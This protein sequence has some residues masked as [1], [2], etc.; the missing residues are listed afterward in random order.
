MDNGGESAKHETITIA[1]NIDI[2]F[3]K[4]YASYKKDTIENGNRQLRRD[5]PRE[6]LIDKYA[7]IDTILN[8]VNNRPLKILV[9]KTPA[10]YYWNV[11]G[12]H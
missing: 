8:Q 10:E 12:K 9:H 1:V 4:P 2:S 5:S 6:I 11:M 3:C 7:Q